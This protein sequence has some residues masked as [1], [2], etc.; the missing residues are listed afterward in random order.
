MLLT[1]ITSQLALEGKINFD[2]FLAT[3]GQN[4]MTMLIIGQFLTN[5][6]KVESKKI[7]FTYF[8]TS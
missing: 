5:P 2:L 8:K 4:D 1:E 7:S 3:F 6:Y